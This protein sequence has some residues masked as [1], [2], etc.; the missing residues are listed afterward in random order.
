[1]PSLAKSLSDASLAPLVTGPSSATDNAVARFDA[2]TGKLLQ[3]SL[4]TID[5]A[6]NLALPSSR[7]LDGRDVSADGTTLDGHTTSIA[8]N[9]ADIATLQT[10]ARGFRGINA[11]TGTTYTF[12]LDDAGKI[13]DHSNASASAFTVPPHASVALASAEVLTCKQ[14]GAGAI[15]LTPGAG[16]TLNA[17][18][19]KT[20][21]T[22]GPRAI[23]SMVQTATLNEWDVYGDLVPS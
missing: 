2:T 22:N 13:V 17:P 23:A 5:D 19:G 4:V 10:Y 8:T 3:N 15:T 16:V 9:A 11:Q 6:G 14:R 7:T 20:L 18:P 21:V 1:M 12:V